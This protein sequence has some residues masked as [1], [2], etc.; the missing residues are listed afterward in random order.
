MSHHIQF[1]SKSQQALGS[2]LLKKARL[3]RREYLYPHLHP[4]II[5]NAQRNTNWTPCAS[6]DGYC[7]S[8]I[9]AFHDPGLELLNHRC[10][11][12]VFYHINSS[13]M[14]TAF[15]LKAAI[16]PY[17]IEQ[18][19]TSK[20]IDAVQTDTSARYIGSTHPSPLHPSVKDNILWQGV[21]AHNEE[22]AN[23]LGVDSSR[24]ADWNGKPG[25]VVRGIDISNQAK[26]TSSVIQQLKA[27]GMS[28]AD[29][30]TE[31]GINVRSV[32]RHISNISKADISGCSFNFNSVRTVRTVS[33][34]TKISTEENRRDIKLKEQ[35]LVSAIN[36]S[37][38]D[39]P[40]ERTRIRLERNDV[41][42][43]G[44]LQPIHP[45]LNPDGSIC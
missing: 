35:P 25:G 37:K 29:I 45:L 30:A 9:L 43:A 14:V 22:L 18:G 33:T 38:Q 15:Y 12:L 44:K 40:V 20:I 10:G 5:D 41:K 2:Y 13:K 3:A 31:L 8:S 1:L 27:E 7:Y 36:I 16:N 24:K 28:N 42:P 39:K 23:A 17:S 21:I 11:A 6:E 32:R 19:H 26:H 34:Y 4:D